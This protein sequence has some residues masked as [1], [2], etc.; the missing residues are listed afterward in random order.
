MAELKH[1]FH[2]HKL[3]LN[4]AEPVIDKEVEC[5]GCRRPIN[6][7]IDAFYKC[8]NSLIDSS[9]SSDCVGF[10]MHK[11]C[12]ELPSTFTHPLFPK[13]P[14]S[15]FALPYKKQNFFSCDACDSESQCFMYCSESSANWANSEFLVCLKCVISEL[16]SLEERNRYHPGHD[17]P[18]TLVQSP[19]LF[20]CHACNTTA[21]DLSYICTTCPFWI[22]ESCANAPITYQSKFHNEHAL[23]LNYSL[24]QQFRQFTCFCSICDENINP[25]DWVYICANCRFFAHV[26]CALSTLIVSN[27]NDEADWGHSNLM[28]FPAH[29]EASLHKVMQQCIMK[30]ANA[31]QHDSANIAEPSPYIKHWAHRHQ[32]ALRNKNATT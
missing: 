14:L 15:L 32:L 29:D 10:Y 4:E 19:A 18:L 20:L 6:K 13:Q 23:I 25:I 16:K 8:N 31:H 28:H 24:P 5:V 26:K 22:H 21:T 3:I 27:M 9:P 2:E 11:T 17:H 7:L 12:S 30:V 1:F